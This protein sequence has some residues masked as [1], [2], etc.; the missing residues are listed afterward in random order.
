MDDRTVVYV[1]RRFVGTRLALSACQTH[2]NLHTW[3]R[4]WF[5]SIRRY[6]AADSRWI[7]P[8]KRATTSGKSSRTSDCLILPWWERM[9]H[10][11]RM[12]GRFGI[13]K[14]DKINRLVQYMWNT[15][16]KPSF[17]EDSSLTRTTGLLFI[18]FNAFLHNF[19]PDTLTI[20]PS[21]KHRLDFYHLSSSRNCSNRNTWKVACRA[22]T[23]RQNT[24]SCQTHLE[25]HIFRF[26]VKTTMWHG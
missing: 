10:V 20:T 13:L 14:I 5:H 15:T 16:P 3:R 8:K 26:S 22:E 7:S 11:V 2:H 21:F 1:A 24:L 9:G 18:F 17:P 12:R 25:G 23:S 19:P 6:D 4:D